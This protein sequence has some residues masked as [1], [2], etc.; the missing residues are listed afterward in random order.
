MGEAS[1]GSRGPDHHFQIRHGQGSLSN[2]GHGRYLHGP[3]CGTTG[4]VGPG[5][6]SSCTRYGHPIGRSGQ[7]E[8]GRAPRSP[9]FVLL[10][11]LESGV[12]EGPFSVADIS[13]YAG[14]DIDRP[15]DASPGENPLGCWKKGSRAQEE[16]ARPLVM[17]FSEDALSILQEATRIPSPKTMDGTLPKKTLERLSQWIQFHQTPVITVPSTPRIGE[18]RNRRPRETFIWPGVVGL[19]EKLGPGTFRPAPDMAIRLEEVARKSAR[20]APRSPKSVLLSALESGAFE[21]PFSV[22]D[23]SAYAGL[24][25]RSTHRC[26]SWGES[27]GVLE[28][29]GQARA[30]RYVFSKDALSILRGI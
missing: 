18:S 5:N 3:G 9:K 24:V 7:K 29:R 27:L 21:G 17:V 13:A 2:D 23:I 4:K 26:L 20:R 6:F 19:L 15:T 25:Y 22:T 14:L 8:W 10:S 30:T 28:K 12:F 11:A 1:T 16:G